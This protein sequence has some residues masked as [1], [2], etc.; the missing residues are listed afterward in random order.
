[1]GKALDVAAVAGS[2]ENR[3]NQPG[4]EVSSLSLFLSLDGDREIFYISDS[5]LSR[6]VAAT[7]LSKDGPRA[8]E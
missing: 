8:A 7:L 5:S 4:A 6:P 3:N 2:I 1:M